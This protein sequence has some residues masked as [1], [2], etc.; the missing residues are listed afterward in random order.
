MIS[1]LKFRK[2]F[3]SQLFE[4]TFLHFQIFDSI[5]MMK[6]H[7]NAV[8]PLREIYPFRNEIWLNT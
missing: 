3:I 8:H 1:W 7:E 6:I 5:V 4:I 2:G